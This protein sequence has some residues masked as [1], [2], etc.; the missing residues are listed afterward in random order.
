MNKFLYLLFCILCCIGYY[1]PAY[2]QDLKE[3]DSLLNLIATSKKDTNLVLLYYEVGFHYELNDYPTA[4]EYYRK[5]KALS[6]E[7]Q[8]KTGI[9]KYIFNYTNILNIQGKL[10]SS[11]ILNKEAIQLSLEK[12]D[13]ILIAKSYVN[14]GNVFLKTLQYDSAIHYYETAKKYAEEPFLIAHVSYLMSALYY[15]VGRYSDAIKESQNALD[16]FKSSGDLY[17]LVGALLNLGNAYIEND[18]LEKGKEQLIEALE[19][20]KRIDFSEAQLNALLSLIHLYIIE[21]KMDDPLVLEYGEQALSISLKQHDVYGIATSYRSLAVHY[22]FKREFDQSLKYIDSSISVATTNELLNELQKSVFSKGLILLSIGKLH[23][24]YALLEQ[25][26]KLQ[27]SI[28]GNETRQRI[29]LE[30]KRFESEKKEAQIQLQEQ[31]IRQK[32]RLNYIFLVGVALL[33]IITLLLF[34]NYRHKQK[35]QQ[36]KIDELEKE[37]LLAATEAILK[38]EEQERSR[39]AKDLHDGLGG[40]LSGIKFSFANMKENL[41]LTPENAREFERSIDMLDSSIREMRRVAHNMMPEM[42][43]KY[44]LDIALK[45]FCNDIDRSGVIKTTYQSLGMENLQI[46]QTIAVATYRIIQ[47]LVNNAIKHAKAS[48]ILVQV[49]VSK[50]DQLLQV[51]IEDDGKG[52]DVAILSNT[53]GIGWSNI[54]HRVDFLKGKIDINSSIEKG[55]SI[56]IE[57]PMV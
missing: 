28:I 7:L 40:M 51:T 17:N 31:Q 36:A 38:G 5:G 30:E 29:I 57:I 53:K 3:R 24:G 15:D 54:Q 32:N 45:E 22:K 11:M 52:F 44:G 23:E 25:S 56:L 4:I 43:L 46:E 26:S 19:V 50:E 27:D 21:G 42:L 41:I 2:T 1:T 18:Q 39:L 33:G 37:K 55:S 16:F 13:H 14:T 48:H 47:E 9:I 12:N 10:D 20:S 49:H 35:L 8:Y 6:E 34:R